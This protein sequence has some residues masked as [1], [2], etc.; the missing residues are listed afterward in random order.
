M[1]PSPG[2]RSGG[3]GEVRTGAGTDPD[4]PEGRL[5]AVEDADGA[6]RDDL[7]ALLSE[8]REPVERAL[9]RAVDVLGDVLPDELTR[10]VRAGVLSGGKRLRPILCVAAF[11]ACGPEPSE[12]VRD[13][14][15]S[16]ELVHAYSLMHDDLPCMDDADLRRG[17]PTPH[18]RFGEAPTTV[19]AAAL[20][21]AAALQAWRAA[22]ALGLPEEPRRSVVRVLMEAAG[23]SGMVG[24]QALDLLGEERRLTAEELDDVHR[25]KT[26]AL[27]AA[28]PRMGGLAAGSSGPVVRALGRY[29]R[30]L[31]LA[32]Q[33][34]D[35]VLDATSTPEALGKEPSD[36]ELAKSTYVALH[37][38]DEARRR[39]RAEAERAQEILAAAGVEDPLL[40]AL[41][42]FAVRRRA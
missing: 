15:V 16:L 5:R 11:R 38:L 4:D 18:R 32:F 23:A 22:A 9:E 42:E 10:I 36:R 14:A 20:V 30:S 26:G 33:I 41:A 25:R 8:E 19:A 21:P 29:G 17:R 12:P 34:T 27:L 31:G 28:G 24:G 3:E 39:A 13:L 35:D 2:T 40:H 37:G 6:H 1:T 7:E